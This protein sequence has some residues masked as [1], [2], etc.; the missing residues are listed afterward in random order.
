MSEKRQSYARSLAS[1]I[2]GYQAEGTTGPLEDFLAQE[3]HLPGPR[4]N[5][6][7]ADAFADAMADFAA[8]DGDLAF[9][10]AGRLAAISA[11][12]APTGDPREFVAF[13]GT[14]AAGA[15]GAVQEAYREDARHL[16][17]TAARDARWRMR[18][19]SAMGLQR[20]LDVDW[21]ATVASVSMW[22]RGGDALEARAALAGVAEPRLLDAPGHAADAL[23]L[24]RI[25]FDALGGMERDDDFGVLKKGLS[26][27][28][29]VV[30]A[31]VPEAGFEYMHDLLVTC[32]R[33]VRR[34][35]AENLKKKR[36]ERVDARKVH[37]LEAL[38]IG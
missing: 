28:L 16:L 10:L 30:V 14:V 21:D 4:G 5:L 27:S 15:V 37:E 24:H 36:L 7:L 26:Y 29:S 35:V 3:S 20:L 6:E 23:E 1:L 17:R 12:D 13:C 32:D 34:I 25:A 19:A 22:V 9:H 38:L 2:Q 18:E 33:D 8:E 11:C 31:S